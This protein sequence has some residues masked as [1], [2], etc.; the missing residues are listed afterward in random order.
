[1]EKTIQT[2]PGFADPGRNVRFVQAMQAAIVV[3]ARMLVSP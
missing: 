1:M 3:G 2:P